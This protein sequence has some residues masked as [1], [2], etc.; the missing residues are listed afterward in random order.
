MWK[1]TISEELDIS[2]LSYKISEYIQYTMLRERGMTGCPTKFFSQ[3]YGEETSRKIMEKMYE[4]TE[5]YGSNLLS[6]TF[7]Y[8]LDEKQ[9]MALCI[10]FISTML[11]TYDGKQNIIS[12]KIA[13]D[14]KLLKNIKLSMWTSELFFFS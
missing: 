8:L 14:L 4:V 1:E 5:N 7:C 10:Y 13:I 3:A 12:Y 2:C 6:R 11:V 9:G